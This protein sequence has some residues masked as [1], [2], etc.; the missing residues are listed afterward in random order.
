M[1]AVGST[2]VVAT[3]GEFADEV[4]DGLAAN[5]GGVVLRRPAAAVMAEVELLREAE[6]AAA[7]EARRVLHEKRKDEWSAKH[8]SWKDEVQDKWDALMQKLKG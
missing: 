8:E 5:L 7:K 6:E 2:A 1:T 3:V 4:V